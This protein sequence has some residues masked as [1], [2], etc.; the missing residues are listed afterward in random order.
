M[1]MNWRITPS[2]PERAIAPLVHRQVAGDHP[3]QRGLAGAVRADQRHL[4]ALADPERHVGEELPPVRQRVRRPRRRRRSPRQRSC[5]VRRV[6][7]SRLAGHAEHPEP[8]LAG[9]AAS[10]CQPCSTSQRCSESPPRCRPTTSQADAVRG[11]PRQPARQQRVQLGL[12]DVDRRVATRSARTARRPAPRPAPRRGSGRPAP[13]RRRVARGQLA[14][15]GVDVDRV[16]GRARGATVA[17]TH[18]IGPYPQPRSSNG[19]GRSPGRAASA[20][21]SSTAVPGSSRPAEKTPPAA[22]SAIGAPGRRRT[23]RY[24]GAPARAGSALK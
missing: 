1:P 23:R 15:P 11:Q 16:D 12:A 9:V 20:L 5:P 18:A 22:A 4:R 2:P 17:S 7:V 14:G 24:G 3:Q 8:L 6:A 21:R 19:P 13:T 10:R